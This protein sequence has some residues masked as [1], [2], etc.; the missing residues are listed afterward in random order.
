MYGFRGSRQGKP[1]Y[2][3]TNVHM[4]KVLILSVL[5]SSVIALIN[6]IQQA[7]VNQ[8]MFGTSVAVLI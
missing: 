8:L 7:A 6:R 2:S 5:T 1:R 4:L 3:K